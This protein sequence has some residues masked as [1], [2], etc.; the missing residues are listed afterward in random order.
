[1]RRIRATTDATPG[2]LASGRS[3]LHAGI[4]ISYEHLERAFSF[5]RRMRRLPPLTLLSVFAIA[6]IGCERPFV[7]IATPD[8]TVVAPDLSTAI[9]APQIELTVEAT[10]F[11]NITRVSLN[12][13]D[14]ALNVNTGNWNSIVQ[15]S[16]GIN[17]LI[18]E[19]FDTENVASVDTLYALRL[20]ISRLPSAPALPTGRGGHTASTLANGSV[21]VAGGAP[22]TDLP[23]T[24]EILRYTPS[25]GVFLTAATRL[26]TPR[27]GH[28]ASLLP[29]GRLLFAGGSSHASLTSVQTLVESAEIFNPATDVVVPLKFRGNPIRR[30]F[31]SADV[32]VING[33]TILDLYGGRG[34][35]TYTPESRL[36]IRSDIRSFHLKGDSLIALSPAIGGRLIGPAW[37]HT[38]TALNSTASTPSRY[39]IVSAVFEP[40]FDDESVAIIDFGDPRGLVPRFVSLPA[41]GRSQHASVRL[42]QELVG[43]SGGRTSE[44]ALTHSIEIYS[45]RARRF[46]TVPVSNFQLVDRFA[47]SVSRIA[48]D[49][50]LVTGGFDAAGNGIAASDIIFIAL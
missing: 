36:G 25:T 26:A 42:G 40:G 11:R 27:V 16:S 4:N 30:A 33:E 13:A 9:T 49:R 15:L 31:H 47:H 29:D 50:V 7:D 46:F 43:I 20:G 2:R 22:T 41:V 19:A 28:S 1:M 3:L 8:V 18:V 44:G 6:M 48:S 39:L 12:G 38:Q 5:R 23:A 45:D 14:M 17:A 21:V 35:I 34:D 24:D 10:S 37:G 32:R